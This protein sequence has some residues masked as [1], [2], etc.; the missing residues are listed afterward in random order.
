VGGAGLRIRLVFV[1][2]S[3]LFALLLLAGPGEQ[4]GQQR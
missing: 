1:I 4:P 3:L 2:L